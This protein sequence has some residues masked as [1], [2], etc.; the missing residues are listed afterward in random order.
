M[1]G[2]SWLVLSLASTFMLL[3]VHIVHLNTA[4]DSAIYNI[5]P[6]SYLYKRWPFTTWHVK[7]AMAALIE[8]VQ[9]C[10]FAYLYFALQYLVLEY[11]I[12]T[13]QIQ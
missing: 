7:E 4:C 2:R 11:W 8:G 10:R 6:L 13:S 1:L 9:V 5:S 12:M 3:T